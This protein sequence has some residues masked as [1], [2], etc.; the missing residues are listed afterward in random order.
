MF[1]SG[2]NQRRA[3]MLEWIPLARPLQASRGVHFD[4]QA[5]VMAGCQCF[6]LVFWS[7]RRS[8]SHH[9]TFVATTSLC[10]PP[11]RS[12]AP[13]RSPARQP[14]SFPPLSNLPVAASRARDSRSQAI[15][16]PRRRAAQS[17]L[18]GSRR[19]LPAPTRCTSSSSCSAQPSPLPAPIARVSTA[20]RTLWAPET[21]VAD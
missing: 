7:P 20:R 4:L 8:P 18:H 21:T 11:C 19:P 17:L 15:P 5:S 2:S 14:L 1:K 6:V 16:A 12:R 3:V 10:T 13:V 9:H